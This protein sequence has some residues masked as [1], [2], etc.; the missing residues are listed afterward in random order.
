MT[1]EELI[2]RDLYLR[3][4]Y[5][6]QL[7]GPMPESIFER[8]P[9]LKYYPENPITKLNLNGTFYDNYIEAS[10]NRLDKAVIFSPRTGK[11][12][13]NQELVEM[14][15][16]A[17]KYF[18]RMG[19]TEKTNVGVILLESVEEAVTLLALNKIGCTLKY[20]DYM[21]TVPDMIES[22][23]HAGLDL[24]IADGAFL[25]LLPLLNTENKPCFVSYAQ[26]LQGK[27]LMSFEELYSINDNE[28]IKIPEYD[29]NKIT[30]KINSSGTTGRS[31]PINH[32]N[33]SIN[34]AVQ[35]MLYAGYPIEE[36]NVLIKN[37]PS[38]IGLG[39]FTTL[40]TGLI[41]GAEIIMLPS[42]GNTE[43]DMTNFNLFIQNFKEYKKKFNLP[44]NAKVSAF[45]APFFIKGLI[46]DPRVTDL[47]S[48]GVF[49][50][51]GSKMEKNELEELEIIAQ[52]KGYYN[53][54]LNGYGQNEMAGAVALNTLKN[55]TNGSAGYPVIGTEI[56]IIDQITHR[57][58]NPGEEGLIIERSDSRFSEYD[59][60]PEESKNSIIMLNDGENWFNS[61]DIGYMNKDG[62][63]FIKDRIDRIV[64]RNDFKIA[65]DNIE[66]KVNKL[67]IIKDCA[68]IKTLSGGSTEEIAIFIVSSTPYIEEIIRSIK[69]SGL[70]S[71]FEM[72]NEFYIVDSIPY[73]GNGKKDY[74]VLKNKRE[75]L[76]ETR[77]RKLKK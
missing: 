18:I 51:A 21:K 38:P 12:Y 54:I 47:S 2:K 17:I 73:K 4:F 13:T 61:K 42:E 77:V 30:I 59:K 10:K 43:K 5:L 32:T 52:K 19:V 39:L 23:E 1:R 45:T 70:L 34:A 57:V 24:F 53:P 25:N 67:P 8:K 37:I 14:T 44:E 66:L 72:P 56:R 7:Q 11:R 28:E 33:Y 6:N 60:M 62:F 3:K 9:W 20:I 36:G 64:K 35:K 41:S 46:K 76:I 15:N 68:T 49:L 16:K 75:S 55:N 31:K 22:V 48:G 63:I 65:L 26:N 58:L 71:E 27:N 50:G 69:N 40:Y 29:S 74:Q